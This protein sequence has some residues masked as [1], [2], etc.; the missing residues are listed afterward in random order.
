MESTYYR[1]VKHKVIRKGKQAIQDLE[2]LASILEEQDLEVIF[3]EKETVSLI[4][5]I[6][7]YSTPS[8]KNNSSEELE[9]MKILEESKFGKT[10][11]RL[12]KSWN[13]K[14]KRAST[15]HGYS[16]QSPTHPSINRQTEIMSNVLDILYSQ[17][18]EKFETKP[19]KQGDT[20]LDTSFRGILPVIKIDEGGAIS[21][22]ASWLNDLFRKTALDSDKWESTNKELLDPVLEL[23]DNW[24]I[25][26]KR[27]ES[28]VLPAQPDRIRK[29]RIRFDS[30]EDLKRF[31]R[32][33]EEDQ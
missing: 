25:I 16:D 26:I 23:M 8:P 15:K 27:D 6:I 14:Q 11:G 7:S 31:F 13:M 32:I 19:V 17:Y 1:T 12:P 33:D 5:S 20:I 24:I 10:T 2:F 9:R 4:K 29:G 28:F 3:P 18:R 21:T 22:K 30:V